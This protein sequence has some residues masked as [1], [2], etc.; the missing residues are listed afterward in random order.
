MHKKISVNIFFNVLLTLSQVAF[1]VITFPYLSRVLKPDG[2]GTVNFIDNITQ[3]LIF[4]SA[5]GVP[6]YGMREISKHKDDHAAI[7]RIFSEL[8]LINLVNAILISTAYFLAIYFFLHTIPYYKLYFFGC[9]ILVINVFTV[10]WLYQG[11]EEFPFI[12]TR[13]IFIKIISICLTFLF[14]KSK[15]DLNIYYILLLTTYFLNAVL[16]ITFAYRKFGITFKPS[17]TRK[18]TL[19][20]H[21]KP[22]LYIFSAN[23]AISIFLYF[24][25]VILG[26][27]KG[28]TAVGFYATATKIVK[29]PAIAIQA[30]IMVFVP[31]ISFEY[32]QNNLQEVNSLIQRSF[33]FITLISV[34][35][36]IGLFCYADVA[37]HIFAGNYYDQCILLLRVMCPIIFFLS[38][39]NIFIWEILTP[40]G[41][42]K[43]FLVTV[44]IAMIVS[45]GLNLLLVPKISYTG[46]SIATLATEFTVAL[47]AWIFARKVFAFKFNFSNLLRSLAA[48][49]PFI[50]VC[51]LVKHY[52]P[53]NIPIQ[54]LSIAACIILYFSIHTFVYRS[55]II[56]ELVLFVRSK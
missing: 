33:D 52:S 14:V 4:I 7:K 30:V 41:K 32:K 6:V 49:L 24:D 23:L 17:L 44:S 2:Q 53:G 34:P 22:I 56:K 40:M 3:Y 11:M 20:S 19:K 36:T 12:T 29:L 10:D 55:T 48:S 54:L 28:Y 39:T 35:I 25:S 37:I 27:F 45:F 5:I 46:S 31:R 51:Y 1:P 42:E 18:K 8:V 13:N 21:I 26:L 47:C 16:N 9:F 50:P 38:L 43:Y 15:A